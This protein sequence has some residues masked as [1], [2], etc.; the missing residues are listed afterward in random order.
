MLKA[1]V[2]TVG[3]VLGEAGHAFFILDLL[4]ALDAYL[5]GEYRSQVG[6]HGAD[7]I[8]NPCSG[9]EKE[10]ERDHRQTAAAHQN[11]ACEDGCG[12]A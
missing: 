3:T 5:A 4:H 2:I 7:R 6:K 8:I 1:D 9:D 11:H 12:N 10:Q